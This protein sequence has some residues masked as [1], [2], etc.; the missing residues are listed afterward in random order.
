MVWCGAAVSC[1][2]VRYGAVWCG[3]VLQYG[4]AWCGMVTVRTG[5]WKDQV[6]LC[7]L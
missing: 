7:E 4:M 1:G 3:K 6:G 5:D 2:M